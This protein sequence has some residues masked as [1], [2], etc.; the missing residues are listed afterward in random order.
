M[1]CQLVRQGRSWVAVTEVQVEEAIAGEGD[2]GWYQVKVNVGGLVMNKSQTVNA[3]PDRP[4]DG[5]IA[6]A[7]EGVVGIP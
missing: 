1:Y 5:T 3:Q 6:S 7:E 4:V 2:C